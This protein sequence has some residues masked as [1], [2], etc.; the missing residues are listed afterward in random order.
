MTTYDTNSVY[1]QQYDE[2]TDE[3]IAKKD[4]HSF[5]ASIDRDETITSR[6]A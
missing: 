6:N 4:I 3:A 2:I 5:E 1:R